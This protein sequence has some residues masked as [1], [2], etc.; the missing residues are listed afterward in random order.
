MKKNTE[1][2]KS[3]KGLI[4]GAF[5]TEDFYFLFT[6]EN[7]K[8]LET[9]KKI[10]GAF[11]CWDN[12]PTNKLLRM[13]LIVQIFKPAENHMISDIDINFEKKQTHFS[14]IESD[15]EEWL[16][17]PTDWV[18]EHGPSWRDGI[19]CVYITQEG[20]KEAFNRKMFLSNLISKAE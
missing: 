4:M 19:S 13:K 8:Q 3:L 14:I 10:I 12:K 11:A 18:R 16:L 6:K 7:I 15:F 17:H 5:Y 20:S 9:K 1:I 2:L